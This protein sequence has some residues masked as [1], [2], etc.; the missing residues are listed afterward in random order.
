M[1]ASASVESLHHNWA[2]E[3]RDR[4]GGGDHTACYYESF[5]EED[6]Q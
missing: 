6:Q 4:K 1:A 2:I 5:D 3:E